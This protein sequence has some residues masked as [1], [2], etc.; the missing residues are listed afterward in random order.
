MRSFTRARVVFVASI[1]LLGTL[2]ACSDDGGSDTIGPD[3]GT[4]SV[5]GA[6]VT[7][8]A[9]ALDKDV[10]IKVSQVSGLGAT[11]P[12]GVTRLGDAFSFEPHG[13]TFLAPVT[14]KIAAPG[15]TV[16]VRLDDRADST[17]KRVDATFAGDT[18]TIQTSTFSIYAAASS[19]GP[20]AMADSGRDTGADAADA[21]GD[22]A[23]DSGVDS[24][25]DLAPDS[26]VDSAKD[27]APEAAG[28][29][30]VD[31]TVDG[32]GDTTV[33]TTI[34]GAGDTTVDTG[35]VDTTIDAGVDTTVDTSVDMGAG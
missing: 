6:S 22:S 20:D 9:G 28:D 8:P 7:I 21:A 29:T 13:Q 32:G 24:A 23:R 19:S 15:S 4:V 1:L 27:L 26:G 34:D 3:G 11:L 25:K 35:A 10:K 31:T 2:S 5:Q 12:G 16:A 18:A 17:W 30:T 33:D 14:I